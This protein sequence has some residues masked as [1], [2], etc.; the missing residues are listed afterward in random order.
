MTR[1]AVALALMVVSSTVAVAADTRSPAADP[2]MCG[3]VQG[4]N[5]FI[6]RWKGDLQAALAAQ[7]IA[8]E[9]HDYLTRRADE[10][11]SAPTTQPGLA[12][13]I[14]YCEDLNTLFPR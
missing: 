2:A 7:A 1:Y 12:G 10:L 14:R 3:S 4:F 9:V 5:L 11:A 13:M 6:M 8:P